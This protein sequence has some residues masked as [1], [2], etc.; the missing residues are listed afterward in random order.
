MRLVAID[1]QEVRAFAQANPDV[2]D[3]VITPA[4]EVAHAENHLV[5]E[6]LSVA[7]FLAFVKSLATV[8]DQVN[9]VAKLIVSARGLFTWAKAALSGKP[10]TAPA[11][12][13]ERLLVLL[14]EAHANRRAGVALERLAFITGADAEMVTG[15]LRALEGR[16][17]VRQSR[18]GSWRFKSA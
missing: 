2:M 13:P 18:D 8:I 17:V 5:A 14:F 15:A 4:A 9:S 12:L 7:L 10:S 6:G 1:E 3:L 11:P 16:G